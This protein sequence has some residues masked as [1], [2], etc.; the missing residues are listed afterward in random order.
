MAIKVR[1]N[2]QCD[3]HH[4]VYTIICSLFA[5]YDKNEE[6]L[7]LEDQEVRSSNLVKIFLMDILVVY[8]CM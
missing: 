8:T 5:S 6:V 2:H 4:G 1:G 7:N 3:L